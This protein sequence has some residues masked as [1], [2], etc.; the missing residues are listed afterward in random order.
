MTLDPVYL[1]GIAGL[2]RHIQRDVDP[3]RH[4]D[5]AETVWAEYLDP[6]YGDDGPVLEP[7]GE[8][9]R[10]SAPAADL[11]VRERPFDA[12]HGLD[13]GTL[14]PTTFTNGVT[15]DVAQAAMAAAPSSLSLHRERTIVTGA[16]SNDATVDVSAD[17]ERLDDEHGRGRV[18]QVPAVGRDQHRVVHWLTLYLAESDHAVEHADDVEELL[19]LDGPLY[20]TELANWTGSDRGLAALAADHDLVAEVVGNYVRLVDRFLDRGVPLAG[21]VKSGASGALVHALP[22]EVGTPWANDTAFF[23]QVLDGAG[24]D[25][26]AWTNWFV[27]RLGADGTLATVDVPGV[28]R[29]RDPAAYE[30]AF[31]V[32][33]DPR[34][35]LSFRVELPVGF[36]RDDAV[37]DRIRRYVLSEVAA[38]RGPPLPVRKADRLARIGRQEG[39]SLIDR[40]ESALDSAE[41]RSYDDQRW[42]TPRGP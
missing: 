3:D 26:L 40:L 2:A 28:D 14:G 25:A 27:S 12:V 20:P 41:D 21:F 11:G 35:D 7:V 42:R 23:R 4:R 39:A 37:R 1:D 13:A 33:A 19:V 31:F 24:D 18:E 38:E 30:V 6:L 15:L 22:D 17:W 36:A 9:T 8:Q 16:H 5:L 29:A 10:Y 34:T 32:V